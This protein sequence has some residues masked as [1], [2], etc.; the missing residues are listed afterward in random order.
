MEFP[1]LAPVSLRREAMTAFGG[2]CHRA[3]VMTGEFYDM[4]NMSG[5]RYPL[6]SPRKGRGALSARNPGLWKPEGD[7]PVALANLDGLCVLDGKTLYFDQRS[8]LFQGADLGLSDE[9]PKQLIPFGTSLIVMPDKKYINLREPDD[10]GDLEAFFVPGTAVDLVFRLCNRD[11]SVYEA[12]EGK[13]A[14]AEPGDGTLWLDTSNYAT[15]GSSLLMQYDTALEKWIPLRPTYVRVEATGIGAAFSVGDWISFQ[16]DNLAD[17]RLLRGLCEGALE[18]VAAAADHLVLD[19]S[20]GKAS[21]ERKAVT[22]LQ[23][24]RSMPE[25]DFLF[26]SGNRLWGCRYGLSPDGQFVNRIYGS[27]LGDFRN[28][29]CFRGD[30]NDSVSLRCST[31]GPWTGV[32]HALGQPLFFKEN[33]LHRISGDRPGSF[34]LQTLP[35]RGVQ[36]GCEKSLA[37]VNGLLYYKAVDGVVCFDGALPESVS[38]ALGDVAYHGAVAGALGQKY[39]V[40]MVDDREQPQLFCY[41]TLRKFWHR[42]DNTRAIALCA[43]KNTL[44]YIEEGA[45]AVGILAGGTATEAP[46]RW[47]AET[48]FWDSDDGQSQYLRRITVRLSLGVGAAVRFSVQ[49]DDG[50]SWQSLGGISYGG[51]DGACSIPLRLRRCHRLRLRIEGEGEA[52]IYGLFPEFARGG[53]PRP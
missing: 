52:L 35:C 47:F 4:E 7:P 13:T 8:G 20:M 19:F 50:D 18:V 32:I 16:G 43:V 23:V 11:G 51:R 48:G 28:W 42:E 21:V 31:P 10:Q 15:G 30:E 25:M 1:V 38:Q 49:Y 41:D 34:R 22:N 12:R 53:L 36:E 40:S 3:Q 14:P 29:N 33:Y 27:K 45:P 39:Y 2:Y 44:Y 5:D 17:E 6:L 26:E 37:V 24:Q 46:V 9:S